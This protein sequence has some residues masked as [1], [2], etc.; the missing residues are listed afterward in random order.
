[1]TGLW[2]VSGRSLIGGFEER[3]ALDLDYVDRWSLWRDLLLL[4]RT[5]PAV[6]SARGA[7]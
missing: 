3:L 4:A 6:L 7:Q 2:Q 5:V 1:M